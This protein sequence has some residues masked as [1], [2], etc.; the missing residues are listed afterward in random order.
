MRLATES[1]MPSI[2]QA[3]WATFNRS[4]A[5][6]MA[7]MTPADAELTIRNAIHQG[8]AYIV[9]HVLIVVDDG[10]PPF[11]STRTL[12]EQLVL[13]LA[14]KGNVSAA[15][16]ALDDIARARDCTHIAVGDTQIG[17]MVPYYE[18]AGFMPLGVQ[19]FKEVTNGI[20]P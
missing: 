18:A 9:E 13:K 12:F 5:P 7:I 1:D 6:Q 14:S 10:C 19:L 17:K 15:V 20:S 16:A 3:A 4:P 8:R 11:S 2:M